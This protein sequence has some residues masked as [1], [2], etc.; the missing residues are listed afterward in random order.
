MLGQTNFL[1]KQLTYQRVQLAFTEK[2]D[3][4]K[5]DFEAQCLTWPPEASYIRS[6]KSELEL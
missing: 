1:E 3:D 4:L 6:F 5:K 2:E